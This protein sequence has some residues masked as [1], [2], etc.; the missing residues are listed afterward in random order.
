[1]KDS[2]SGGVKE[3]SVGITEYLYNDNDTVINGV[4][5]HRHRDFIV[6]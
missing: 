3:K 6:S 5:K 1:M 4:L 2:R